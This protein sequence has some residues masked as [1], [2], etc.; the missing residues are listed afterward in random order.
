LFQTT[1]SATTS[2][3]ED[4][5]FKGLFYTGTSTKTL[6][7]DTRASTTLT[8]GAVGLKTGSILKVRKVN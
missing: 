6:R 4:I 5:N 1:S 3:G 8:G 2:T 7:I